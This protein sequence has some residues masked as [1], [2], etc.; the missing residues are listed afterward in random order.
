MNR[1]KVINHQIWVIFRGPRIVCRSSNQWKHFT[2][3]HPV[4]M[5]TFKWD[6]L[7]MSA[8]QVKIGI[9][10]GKLACI[11]S[12][13]TELY[14]VFLSSI[15]KK[16]KYLR[17]FIWAPVNFYYWYTTIDELLPGI[18]KNVLHQC[19]TKWST[20]SMKTLP[21]M[22]WKRKRLWKIQMSLSSTFCTIFN[23]LST[24][25]ILQVKNSKHE[26]F[27]ALKVYSRGPANWLNFMTKTS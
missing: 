13:I 5:Q 9:S 18:R 4:Y 14:S 12:L 22:R 11:L 25:G 23:W 19:F 7:L 15:K 10:K 24:I 2:L 6:W 27:I 26:W 1:K 21:H 16:T 8:G 3:F 17:L 20:S